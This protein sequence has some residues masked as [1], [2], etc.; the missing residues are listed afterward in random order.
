MNTANAGWIGGHGFRFA[1]FA[2]TR[3]DDSEI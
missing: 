2:V 3:N 1:A